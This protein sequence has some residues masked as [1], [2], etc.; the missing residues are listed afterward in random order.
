MQGGQPP[1]MDI[2]RNTPCP[3]GHPTAGLQLGLS[4]AC[5]ALRG[6][7]PQGPCSPG[8]W[9]AGGAHSWGP[10]R[11]SVGLR[12][13]RAQKCSCYTVLL[14]SAAGCSVRSQMFTLCSTEGHGQTETRWGG[15]ESTAVGVQKR[16]TTLHFQSLHHAAP[17][18]QNNES[19]VCV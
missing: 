19:P 3:Q 13:N 17:A 8:A 11:L 10:P 4:A 14:F 1:C 18:L 2:H 15:G 16:P 5:S 6:P 7:H 12:R 9:L